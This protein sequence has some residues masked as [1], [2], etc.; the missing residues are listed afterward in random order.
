MN[1]SKWLGGKVEHSEWNCNTCDYVYKMCL[2]EEMFEYP[3][4]YMNFS[5]FETEIWQLLH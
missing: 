1:F 5:A 3:K 4:D 2:G